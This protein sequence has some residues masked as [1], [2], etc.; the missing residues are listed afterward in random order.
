M[1]SQHK[2]ALPRAHPRPHREPLSAALPR[3][4]RPHRLPTSRAALA[5]PLDT[6][7]RTHGH[8]HPQRRSPS[9]TARSRPALRPRSPSGPDPW[10]PHAGV[11]PSL[12]DRGDQE[13]GG[14][15]GVVRP[16]AGSDPS[17]LS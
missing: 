16:R 2:H 13:G 6:L 3:R 15:G 4:P 7:G 11:F 9:H 5:R 8:S 14:N 17:Y 12:A 1:P 10:D